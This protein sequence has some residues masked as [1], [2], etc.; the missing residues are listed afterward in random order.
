MESDKNPTVINRIAAAFIFF[1]RL[2]IWKISNPPQKAYSDVVT[3]WPLTGWV[4]GGATALLMWGLSYLMAWPAAVI[5]AMVCRVIM[6]GALHEDG[7][8]DFCDGFG[9]GGDKERILAIMKDSHT[10]TYGIIALII[11]FL[12]AATILISL[13]PIVAITGYFAGDAFCKCCAAQIPDRLSYARAEGAKNRIV[14]SRMSVKKQLIC[15]LCGIIPTGV[16]AVLVD[17]QIVL[18]WVL[19]VMMMR[20][21]ISF[22]QKKIGG[23]TGDCCGA[24]L[25]ICE[26]TFLISLS[27][28]YTHL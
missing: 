23:Y 3:Y 9:G 16:A 20:W 26:L 19:P 2:P 25:L 11:Y 17:W 15:T 5:I 21:L 10:G 18:A 7:L 22:M 13:P 28:I 4:T 12:L 27:M 14:Y 8:A 1:T 6:T 24:T